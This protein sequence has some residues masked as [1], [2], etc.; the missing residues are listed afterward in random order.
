[1]ELLFQ[2]TVSDP[3]NEWLCDKARNLVKDAPTNLLRIY[4]HKEESAGQYLAYQ[5]PAVVQISEGMG[6]EANMPSSGSATLRYSGS[7][8]KGTVVFEDG[9]PVFTPDAA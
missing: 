8:V 9:A 3:V 7:Q 2:E 4:T 6:G 5:I 1:M